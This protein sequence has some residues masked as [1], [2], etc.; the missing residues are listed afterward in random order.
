MAEDCVRPPRN[1]LKV[2]GDVCTTQAAYCRRRCQP[3][4]QPPIPVTH[5]KMPAWAE[6]LTHLVLPA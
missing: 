1:D 4:P 2:S 3:P 5:V 6:S